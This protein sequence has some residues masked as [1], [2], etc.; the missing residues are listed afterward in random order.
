MQ[1]SDDWDDLTQEGKIL[2]NAKDRVHFAMLQLRHISAEKES[3]NEMY[4]IL[5]G[6]NFKLNQSLKDLGCNGFTEDL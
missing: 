5:V 6:L 4:E 3:Y 1:M 2:V